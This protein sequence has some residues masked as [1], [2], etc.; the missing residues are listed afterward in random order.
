MSAAVKHISHNRD[1]RKILL[2]GDVGKAF[3]DISALRSE[4]CADM[5]QAIDTAADNNFA[6]IAVVMS[7]ISA[8][9]SS[10]LKAL[11]D[12]CDSKIILLARMYEEPA[13]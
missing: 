13:G 11:R 1:N 8:G 6:V 7:G 3:S 4:I 10:G 2:V 12:N 9:L 5:R